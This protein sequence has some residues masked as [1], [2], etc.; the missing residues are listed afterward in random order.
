M[1]EIRRNLY[2]IETGKNLFTLIIKET[3]KN[4]I[5]LEKNLFELKKYYDYDGIK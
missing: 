1:K 3:E 2:K 5:E 4:L